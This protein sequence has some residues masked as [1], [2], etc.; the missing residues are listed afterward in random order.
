MEIKDIR[1]PNSAKHAIGCLSKKR[2]LEV[3][4]SMAAK[5]DP[6]IDATTARNSLLHREKM[7]STGIGNGIALP[8]ARIS[9]L[10]KPVA[11]VVTCAHAIEFDAIDKRPV[12]IFVAVLVP[13]NDTGDH[14][15]ILASIADKLTD[16]NTLRKLRSANS[17]QA[18]H[19]ALI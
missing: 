16:R 11:A 1:A 12:D 2:V 6:S 4:G 17:D 10:Q 7:G 14:L 3:L 9:G 18:L 19:K 13:Q 5:A 8:H 15:R